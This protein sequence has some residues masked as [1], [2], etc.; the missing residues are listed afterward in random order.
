[1]PSKCLLIVLDGLGDR[2]YARFGHKTP[3]AAARTPALDA[4]AARG[5]SGLYHAGRLGQALPSENAHFAMFGYDLRDFP[6]RGALEALGSGVALAA[7]EVAVLAHFVSLEDVDGRALL[8]QDLP[9][10]DDA[11][12]LAVMAAAGSFV[13]E[14]IQ[15]RFHR[16][17][18]L[19]GVLV[20]SGGALDPRV[21]DSNPMRDGRFLSA[22]V[23]REEAA[24]DP[25]TRR[26]AEALSAYLRFAHRALAPLPVNAERAARGLAPLNGLV[27]QRAGKLKPVVPFSRRFGMRGVSL[28]S[29][30]V[31]RGLAAYLGLTFV[32]APETD[33]TEADM[34]ARLATARELLAGG[35]GF[36]HL[37][38][39]APD[40]AAHTK[41]P[42]AKLAV[43]EALDRALD[44]S[45][46]GGLAPF[47]DDPDILTVVTA[48]HSTPSAGQ[49]VHSGEPV[50]LI[51]CGEG[52]RRDE[53][54]AFDEVTAARGAL[55]PVRGTELMACI[56]NALDR[57]RLA[58]IHDTPGAIDYWP[59]DYEPFR[60][61]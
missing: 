37:H 24:A 48:D 28:A 11:E 20:L 31:F 59:G 7:D 23:A 52:V 41:D 5:A 42:A 60:L 40:E 26:T 51:F 22:V 6:G 32:K 3:L 34:S 47:L 45:R 33:D 30:A 1:M 18:G 29:G 55:G 38:T 9:R 53:L 10:A 8:V 19:F 14:G 4:L 49:L 39:K 44:W 43:I 36:V 2:A 21:T 58:G 17:K 57:C 27:C 61:S 35:A 54:A 12:T 46:G 25:A 50:P 13:H 16:T 56:L 15:V